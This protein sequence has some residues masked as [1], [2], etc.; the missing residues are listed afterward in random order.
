MQSIADVWRV[1]KYILLESFT[2]IIVNITTMI[3]YPG[4]ILQTSLSFVQEESWFQVIMLS[5]FSVSDILGRFLTKYVNT[6][7]SKARC[8]IVIISLLRAICIYTSLQ[9]GFNEEKDSILNTDWFKILNTLILGLGNGFLG[10]I[11]MMMGPYR[12]TNA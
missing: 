10:T 1:Q 8:V 7:H 4:V 3:C 5:L 6:D 2:V 9:I 12:V 11:L